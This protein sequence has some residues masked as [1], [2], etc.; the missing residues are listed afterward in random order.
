MGLTVD[1]FVIF[2]ILLR[3]W[4]VVVPTLA[5][6]A[7]ALMLVLTQVEPEYEANAS[8]LLAGPE[9][10][11][12]TQ[13]EGE[14]GT[15]ELS[16]TIV[17][18][19]VQGD[20]VR[21]QLGGD[22]LADYRV[23]VTGDSILR[24]VATSD[25]QGTPVP[26]VQAVL[27]AIEE[28]VAT[29][30][31]ELDV[32]PEMVPR[33]DVLSEP[34]QARASTAPDGQGGTLEVY[35]ATGSAAI[36]T[37]A[38]TAGAGGNPYT[39][40]GGTLRVLQEVAQSPQ[41]RTAVY[42]GVA[43]PEPFTVHMENR[44][45]API[46]YVTAHG[47]NPNGVMQTLERAVAFLNGE[48]ADR[49]QRAGVDEDRWIRLETLSMPAGAVEMSANLRRPL[50]TI[51]GLG[52]IAAVS[53]AVLADSLIAYREQRRQR[54]QP[55]PSFGQGQDRRVTAATATDTSAEEGLRQE[56]EPE[57]VSGA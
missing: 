9:L 36:L 11:Q 39:A 32:P 30:Q 2:R 55:T 43:S 29:R 16:A 13:P 35:E 41:G 3:R 17:A 53:L 1:V 33:V 50:L 57:Q 46:L 56:K 40:S 6:T 34:T 51:L 25:S 54:T 42:E 19:I 21:D 38:D 23:E 4:W 5:V 20:S 27:Q 37:D 15:T 44:D 14:T 45:M 47:E 52:L 22:S 7:G 31:Q 28:V 24:V 49:Q 26:T 18:E 10:T 48:L 12:G 8:L